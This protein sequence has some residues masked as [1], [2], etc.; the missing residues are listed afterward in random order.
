MKKTLLALGLSLA[1][2][3]AHAADGVSQARFKALET[4]M[5][6]LEA[7]AKAAHREAAE[8][9]AQAQ[10]ARAELAQLKS[11]PSALASAP[12]PAATEPA[13][14]VDDLAAV[15]ALAADAGPDASAAPSAP[16]ASAPSANDALASSG[17]A[18]S[19]NANAFNPAISIILNGSYSHHSRDPAAYVR[20]GFPL[21][22]EGVPS[23]QGL[24]LGES[25]L[26]FAANIDEKFYG[27]VTLAAGSEDGEDRI[28]VEEAFIDTTALPAG[29]SV[30][31]GRFFSNVGYLNSHHA[32]TDNFFDRPLPYQAFLGNQY[33]D[34]GVQVRWVAPTSMFLELG[35]E[36]FRGQ[37]F[38]SGGAT[39]GGVGT[40]TLFA[41]LGGDA[42]ANSEWLAG[43]SMLRSS[44]VD[45][46]D[47]F[48]GDGTLYIAD[49]TWKWAPD[50]NFKDGGVTLRGEYFLDHRDGSFADLDTGIPAA[51]SGSR[52]GA[53]GE[54]VYRLNR[55]WDVG[56]RFDRLWAANDGPLAGDTDPTR[57]TVEA[58]WRNSE[59]SLFR[60]QMSHDKPNA[61]ATDN[62]V[63][64]QYQ[65]S[66]GA[67]GAHKF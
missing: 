6:Q 42:G 38:P 60:L 51:W 35:G 37:A 1:L 10:A 59:F 27:Q 20:A 56:Y 43:V 11:G 22:G 4:R 40:K 54:A 44:A 34:D 21:V 29:W 63:T 17:D 30:R 67:H 13:A 15:D 57:H 16:Q 32:H 28:G 36:V 7:E 3:S 26:S 49:A 33:G 61:T 52:R 31:L 62:A 50:G 12:A 65:T 39:H 45:G 24:S 53:Y 5:A 2:G 18:A 25:E 19:S 64:V 8:A 55:Q 9:K 41:H 48:T 14:P 23:A 58:T 66:L 46:E 47:G